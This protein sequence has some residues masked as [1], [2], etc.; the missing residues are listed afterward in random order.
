VSRTVKESWARLTV[1]FIESL[2]MRMFKQS[3]TMVLFLSIIASSFIMMISLMLMELHLGSDTD[4]TRAIVGL[5]S[6]WQSFFWIQLSVV[7]FIW[8]KNNYSTA[9]LK[10]GSDEEVDEIMR[11]MKIRYAALWLLWHCVLAVKLFGGSLGWNIFSDEVIYFTYDYL[12]SV[13]KQ[14]RASPC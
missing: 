8:T 4:N 9:S 5:V 14:S 2:F 6:V 13:R 10:F 11:S 1:V 7:G 12:I 3:Q